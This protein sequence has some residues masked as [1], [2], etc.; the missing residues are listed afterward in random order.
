MRIFSVNLI[1]SHIPILYL[2][3]NKEISQKSNITLIF[4]VLMNTTI[5]DGGIIYTIE[6]YYIVAS[7][8]V[9]FSVL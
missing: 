3:K 4:I 8:S 5:V 2:Y 7:L 9:G 6:D 1:H